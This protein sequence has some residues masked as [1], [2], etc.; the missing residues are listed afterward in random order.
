VYYVMTQREQ[1]L[2]LLPKGAAGAEIGVAQGD[3]AA[4][5]LAA[6]DPKELHL[7]DPWRHLESGSD[8]LEASD[9]LAS[10]DDTLAQGK[11]FAEPEANAEGDKQY[12]EVVRRFEGDPRVRLH[13][14][15]SYKAA[16]G[17]EDGSLDFVYLD[18]NHH[19][20][21][22][23]RDLNDFAPK[24]KPG[25]LLFGH[26]YFEDGFARKEH[27]GVIDAVSTFLKRSDFRFIMLTWEPFSTFCLARRLDGFAGQLLRNLLESEVAMIEI[28]DALAS[29]YQDKAYKRQNGSLKRIP[30]F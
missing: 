6:A 28:P 8:P 3:F 5:M 10:V 11:T 12:A 21:F 2:P 1:L 14:E 20:E 18:G 27:Y 26:D 24:L 19:Y 4:A 25:G 13:R 22:V 29:N 23:L 17:F 15:Y 9:F 7:I 16:P 30:S